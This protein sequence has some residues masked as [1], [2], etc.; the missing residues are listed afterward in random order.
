MN[1]SEIIKSL[2]EEPQLWSEK[3]YFPIITDGCEQIIYNV[4]QADTMD[5]FDRSPFIDRL[6]LRLA[7]WQWK[8][9]R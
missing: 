6:R 9:R 2:K 5:F 4:F 1:V 3:G 8:R 7:I